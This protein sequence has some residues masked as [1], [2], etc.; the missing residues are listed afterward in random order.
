M[1]GLKGRQDPF[2]FGK[3]TKGDEDLIVI[4][5]HVASAAGGLQERVLGPDAG[6]VKAGGDRMCFEDLSRFVLQ[7]LGAH[8]VH[9]ARHAT[10][11]RRP[12]PRRFDPHQLGVGGGKTRERS[13]RVR[14][15]ANTGD[16]DVG[17]RAVEQGAT[18]FAGLVAD[19]PL[20]F[21]H[22]VGIGMRSDD[23]SDAVMRRL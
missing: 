9:D 15:T 17:V 2:T 11:E 12:R 3:S 6:V 14:S 16:N 21:P 19:D 4:H 1:R 18:L 20:E 22:H 23:R 13:R 7:K 10:P 8:A 5:R